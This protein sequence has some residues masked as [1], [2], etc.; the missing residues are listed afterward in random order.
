MGFTADVTSAEDVER[1][2]VAVTAALGAPIVLV[3]AVV[4][5]DAQPEEIARVVAFL[6]STASESITGARIRLGAGPSSWDWRQA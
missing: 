4:A 5:G 1:L 2:W 3:N 6:A